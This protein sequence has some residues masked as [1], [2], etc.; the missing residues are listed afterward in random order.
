M[1]K[2]AVATRPEIQQLRFQWLSLRF[3]LSLNI[4]P[5]RAKITRRVIPIRGLEITRLDTG[6]AFFDDGLDVGFAGNVS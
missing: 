2:Q 3:Q 4:L 6:L 1:P 5:A